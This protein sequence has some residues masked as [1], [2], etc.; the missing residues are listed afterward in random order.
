[1]NHC[2]SANTTCLSCLT[3]M[4]RQWFQGAGGVIC[5]VSTRV[6]M[7]RHQNGMVE[8]Q[9]LLHVLPDLTKEHALPLYQ[10]SINPQ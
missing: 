4:R 8:H 1:M 2:N 5:S 9:F 10:R 7:Q 3:A 6:R